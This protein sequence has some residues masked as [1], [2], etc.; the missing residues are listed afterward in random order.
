MKPIKIL[1]AIFLI[2]IFALVTILIIVTATLLFILF[3]PEEKIISI[4]NQHAENTLQR[5]I[6]IDEISYSL[7]GVKLTGF[8]IREPGVDTPLFTARSV[9]IT[10]ALLP[11][12]SK[13]LQLQDLYVDG[14]EFRL[15]YKNERYNIENLI[16]D[17]R[18]G[19]QGSQGNFSASL[20]EIHLTDSTLDVAGTSEDL[21]PLI[22]SY[23]INGSISLADTE[24][25]AF[26]S[27]N[28]KLP[29]NR[30]ALS[31]ELIAHTG[32]D[33]FRITGKATLQSFQ[34]DWVYHFGDPDPPVLPYGVTSGTIN[35]LVITPEYTE[36]DID[37]LTSMLK[38][39]D[40]LSVTGGHCRVYHSPKVLELTGNTGEIGSGTFFAKELIVEITKENARFDIEATN[41]AFEKIVPM[42]P[43]LED[44]PLYGKITGNLRYDG[45]LFN[46]TIQLTNGGYRPILSNVNGTFTVTNNK[47]RHE[48]ISVMVMDQPALVSAASTST[49]FDTFAINVKTERFTINTDSDSTPELPFVQ[50][51]TVNGV[52]EADEIL[53][54]EAILSKVS[55]GYSL[56]NGSIQFQRFRSNYYNGILT[57]EA[58]L[59][60]RGNAVD[61][62]LNIQFSN[63]QL[64]NLHSYAERIKNRFFGIASGRLSIAM[65]SNNNTTSIK[66]GTLIIKVNNGKLINTGIQ[67]SLG[68]IL[69]PLR[70]KLKD[71]EFKEMFANISIDHQGYTF[72]TF[73]FNSPDVR[74]SVNGIINHKNIAN[75]NIT[76]LFNTNFL[77]DVPNFAYPQFSKYKKG[78]WYIIPF[79]ITDQNVFET[80]DV[81]ISE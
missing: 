36:G 9:Q 76:L 66:D 69:K 56:K 14:L 24:N 44:H 67:D 75:L 48:N 40:L 50:S 2:K 70:Y 77:Q 79:K 81:I 61:T 10:F 49:Q 30:G 28:L 8:R 60:K 42:I 21:R 1:K 13:Q 54:D 4:I 31:A 12:F 15:D 59:Q 43:P 26:E 51:I 52:I 38:T 25:I 5:T 55:F 23:I 39:G 22:G 58:E 7:R 63:I 11:L 33:N 41:T 19:S 20:P 6:E 73:M 32:G 57:G 35:N 34:L 71:I 78:S 16:E 65:T 3:F 64:Q 47:F 17:I 29:G 18:L 74:A 46:G 62:D 53:V 80:T 72:N 27:L 37:K 68:I 45:K